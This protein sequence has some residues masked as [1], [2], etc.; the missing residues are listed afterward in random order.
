M[1]FTT[2]N[3]ENMGYFLFHSYSRQDEHV[4]FRRPSRVEKSNNGI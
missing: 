4:K 1:S 2:T 3:S